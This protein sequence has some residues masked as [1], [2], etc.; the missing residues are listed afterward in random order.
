MLTKET[1]TI[2]FKGEVMSGQSNA[3]K[4]W[5][6][7]YFVIEVPGYAGM[8]RKVCLKAYSSRVDDVAKFNVGDRV[9]VSYQVESRPY[10][11]GWYTN[12]NLIGI[13]SAEMGFGT[14]N[15]QQHNDVKSGP[16][17]DDDMPL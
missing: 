14:G 6:A 16:V 12:V 9:T 2:F 13:R 8:P 4:T 15:V 5:R 11:M 17:V 1:G 3:G 7:Q 10:K